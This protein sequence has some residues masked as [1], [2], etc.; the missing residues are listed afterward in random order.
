M[1][2]IVY[3][4][5]AQAFFL[6]ALL[7]S[8]ADKKVFDYILLAWLLLN[9]IQLYY[10]NLNFLQVTKQYPQPPLILGGLLPYLVAPLLYF[11]VA[12]LVKPQPFSWKANWYHF[13]PF[14]FMS[15]SMLYHFYLRPEVEIWVA[16]G[17]IHTCAKNLPFHLDYYALIM[18]FFSF[19]YPMICLYLLFK[20]RARIENEFSYHE[21]I[22][23]TWLRHWILLEIIGFWISFIIVWAGEFEWVDFLFSFKVIAVVVIFNIVVIGFFGIKQR[24]IFTNISQFGS[25]T[26]TDTKARKGKYEK[27]GI[28]K[29]DLKGLADRLNEIMQSDQPYLNPKLD[30][31]EL[32]GLVQTKKHY[33]SQ[34]LNDYLNTNFYDYI[35]GFRVE[36]F[37]KR[38]VDPQYHHLSILGIALDCGF[39]SKSSF[40][41]IFK[42]KEGITPSEFKK[43]TISKSEPIKMDD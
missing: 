7:L 5:I 24:A 35:N 40:N 18:A 8:K 38:V 39:N 22:T 6:G 27:S 29:S 10:F 12:A 9:A 23:L 33:L 11:Y 26:D 16:D 31:D 41:H 4:G 32:S 43:T 1:T 25:E 30:I 19:L 2:I 15:L 3:I 28:S 20:H 21:K 42:K 17:Y 34:T 36:E 13:V 37:K 14:V